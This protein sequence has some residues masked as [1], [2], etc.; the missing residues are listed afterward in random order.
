M[1][2]SYFALDFGS[3]G[4]RVARIIK[5]NNVLELANIGWQATPKVIIDYSKRLSS[6]TSQYVSLLINKTEIKTN[7]VVLTFP[8]R[9][10]T[11]GFC[12]FSRFESKYIAGQISEYFKKNF[13]ISSNSNQFDWQK[14]NLVY[15]NQDKEMQ[16]YLA[17]AVSKKLIKH[18]YKFLD[19]LDL[20]A[21][22]I[23]PDI[24]S[25]IRSINYPKPRSGV[26]LDISE[27]QNNII[28]LIQGIP[29]Y[30]SS[31]GLGLAVWKKNIMKKF[32]CN[33]AKASEI[34]Q[35]STDSAIIE[36]CQENLGNIRLEL[37]KH[38][39][40]ASKYLDHNNLKIMVVGAGSNMKLVQKEVL[41]NIDLE[42]IL[43]NP[44]QEITIPNSWEKNLLNK[45]TQY[46]NVMGGALYE[47]V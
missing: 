20:E 33:L 9:L 29:I 37:K 3:T 1:T 35:N 34:L 47:Y 14:L 6:S 41:K 19:N 7:K 18:I 21:L 26:V 25:T 22:A 30:H 31:V 8:A 36:L 10:S 45:A 5:N 16:N 32:H 39:G 15:P 43:P 17:V 2:N 27:S 13:K 38:L 23:E 44:F 42:I 4:I 24:F 46:H 11:L 28:T 40:L 12:Q